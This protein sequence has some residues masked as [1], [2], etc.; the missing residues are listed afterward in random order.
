ME[1]SNLYDQL[2]VGR[3]ATQEEIK[4]AYKRNALTHHPDKGGDEEA[5]KS[6]NRAFETLSDTNRRYN[7]DLQ[8]ERM[9]SRDGANP[10]APT[11]NERKQAKKTSSVPPGGNV[12]EIPSNIETLTVRELRNLLTQLGVRH[13]DCF[14]KGELLDR[15]RTRKGTGGPRQQTAQPSQ[16]PP[17]LQPDSI[18]I[19]ILSIGD[20]ECGKSCL[21]KRY[22][23]GR[24]VQRYIA[25]IGV[26]YGVKKMT[27]QG[28]KTHINFFD[29]SGQND[30]AEIRSEFFKESQG[31][32]L[33]FE[34]NDR[35]TFA[36]LNRWE[37]EAKSNGLDLASVQVVVCGNKTDLPGREVNTSEGTKWASSK[38]YQ[39]METSANSGEG[40]SDVFDGLF[41]RVVSQFLAEKQRL[42]S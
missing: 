13:D 39:Y 27:V 1:A 35:K 2:G 8:L 10:R 12:T 41:G 20:P 36:G 24:F 34:V 7:Y 6:L 31:V 30:Y 33:V 37:R 9:G 42:L 19:K 22:C 5:F 11:G 4:K 25:T 3:N 38:G 32:L 40:V 21:I 16:P 14:E 18:L 29:L 23:E 15:V 28:R 17:P 26:D